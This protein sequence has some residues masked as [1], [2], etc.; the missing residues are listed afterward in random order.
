MADGSRDSGS[1]AGGENSGDDEYD[2]DEFSFAAESSVAQ[3]S[4]GSEQGGTSGQGSR[5]PHVH[6]GTVPQP[7]LDRQVHAANDLQV[8]K[9][10]ALMKSIGELQKE[11]IRLKR[12]SSDHR[13]SEYFRRLQA[14]LGNQDSI[15]HTLCERVGD[16][17]A[18]E[19]IGRVARQGGAGGQATICAECFAKPLHAAR[20]HVGLPELYQGDDGGLRC[21]ACFERRFWRP[22]SPRR[23]ITSGLTRP[24]SREELLAMVERLKSE[25]AA[26]K[27]R[28]R[29]VRGHAQAH[30]ALKQ[31]KSTVAVNAEAATLAA[32]QST[33]ATHNQRAEQMELENSSLEQQVIALERNLEE[34]QEHTRTLQRQWV[35]AASAAA[36]HT[37]AWGDDAMAV[38]LEGQLRLK[39]TQV[40]R[41]KDGVEQVRGKIEALRK[42]IKPLSSE[43]EEL[44]ASIADTRA[45]A[46]DAVYETS[47]RCSDLLDADRKRSLG[48]REDLQQ[49]QEQ[50]QQKQVKW[51]SECEHIQSEYDAE[52]LHT[53]KREATLEQQLSAEADRAFSADKAKRQGEK[54]L[55]FSN[56]E[57]DEQALS[58]VVSEHEAQRS[59]MESEAA[60]VLVVASRLRKRDRMCVAAARA[61]SEDESLFSRKS[62]DAMRLADENIA[63]NASELRAQISVAQTEIS[64]LRRK[65]ETRESSWSERREFLT[66]IAQ[67]EQADA[68]RRKVMRQELQEKLKEI[69]TAAR[70]ELVRERHDEARIWAECR[71]EAVEVAMEEAMEDAQRL[72]IHEAAEAAL[73]RAVESKPD[74]GVV[75]LPGKLLLALAAAA[76]RQVPASTSK[77]VASKAVGTSDAAMSD[78]E[79]QTTSEEVSQRRVLPDLRLQLQFDFESSTSP[80]LLYAE[81]IREA[82]ARMESLSESLELATNTRLEHASVATR[83]EDELSHEEQHIVSLGALK[84]QLLHESDELHRS[85]DEWQMRIG[86]LGYG[87]RT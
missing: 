48:L 62:A 61:L 38:E 87:S 86:S 43:Q 19:L 56:L 44:E 84:E 8:A 82:N 3:Q 17:V 76:S 39:E 10:N 70:R 81:E 46:D 16:D 68:E 80:H 29:Q 24:W 42:L 45:Q 14:E 52:Q 1:S 74:V 27:K 78:I 54:Q 15:I 64:G 65:A 71:D 18:R 12:L 41:M 32:L 85:L 59:T 55:R 34:Q 57:K 35:P 37:I 25:V 58:R 22:P 75:P 2:E 40:A 66:R 7:R 73:A 53:R 21:R 79:M 30:A 6:L 20:D 31:R 4:G 28:C 26:S 36:A 69:Q 50:L 33:L 11:N 47:A 72:K 13:R 51:R 5:L 60:E 83:Y 49:R 9:V 77:P 63:Q 23:Q 67:Q